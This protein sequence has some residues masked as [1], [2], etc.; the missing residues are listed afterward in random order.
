MIDAARKS[1]DICAI[2][3]PAAETPQIITAKLRPKRTRM[4]LRT[5][6]RGGVPDSFWALRKCSR[7]LL[8]RSAT[9]DFDGSL[10]TRSA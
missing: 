3:Q 1:A 6:V 5:P 9:I 4:I 8:A 10:R 2:H 7:L